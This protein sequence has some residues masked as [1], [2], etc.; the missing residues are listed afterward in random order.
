MKKRMIFTIS[1]IVLASL[2]LISGCSKSESAEG[3]PIPLKIGGGSIGGTWFPMMTATMVILNEDI[4]GLVAT[5]VP[6]SSLKNARSTDA[7]ELDIALTN[8]STSNDAWNGNDPF[9]KQYQNMR[10]IGRFL[11][12]PKTWVVRADSGINS[13]KDLSG[14]TVNTMRSGSGTELEFKRA[15]GEYGI[16]FEDIEA[17][18]GKIEHLVFSQATLAMKDGVIDFTIHDAWAPD[19][20]VVEMET[21]FPVK[22][23]PID[24]KMMDSLHDKYAYGE[25]VIPGGTYKGTPDDTLV[26]TVSTVLIARHDLPEELAYQITKAVFENPER[27]SKGFAK[28]AQLSP[29]TAASGVSIPF[30]PGAEKYYKEKGLQ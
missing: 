24:R 29:E 4:P 28:L 2:L 1:S 16:T 19:P 8:V 11:S 25:A 17:A 22:I 6:G 15:L 13:L 14:K 10:A 26:M 7:G 18:G 5:V 9:E 21:V 3:R 23:L 20:A 12:N 30:H 27:L